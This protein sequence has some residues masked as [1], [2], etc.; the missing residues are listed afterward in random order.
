[1]AVVNVEPLTLA[2]VHIVVYVES[3]DSAAAILRIEHGF[4]LSEAYSELLSKS[5]FLNAGLALS[6][7]VR[8]FT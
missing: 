5:V 7:E 6:S 1:V 2:P 3:A 4:V 8:T